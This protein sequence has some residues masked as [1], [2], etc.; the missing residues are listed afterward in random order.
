MNRGKEVIGIDWGGG[1]NSYNG[2][3]FMKNNVEKLL[4][5]NIEDIDF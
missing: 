2:G 1:G 3:V 4:K 5:E